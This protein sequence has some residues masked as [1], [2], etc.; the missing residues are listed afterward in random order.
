MKSVNKVILLGNVCNNVEA[1]SVGNDNVKVARFTVAT[2]EGGYVTQNG[3][4]V[5]EATQ[6]HRVICWRSLADVCERLIGKG[7]SVCIVGS[8]QYYETGAKDGSGK[9]RIT[10]IVAEDVSLCHKKSDNQQQNAQPQQQWGG[11]Q[12]QGGY[13]MQPQTPPTPP[14]PVWDAM[15]GQWVFPQ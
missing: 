15:K 9:I 4:Q 8:I 6:F 2:T 7:D 1:K 13:P 3:K 12:Q 14:Q 5:P 11:S 10:D